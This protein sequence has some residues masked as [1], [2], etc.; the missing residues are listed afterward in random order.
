M[1]LRG[2]NAAARTERDS[3][4]SPVLRCAGSTL[5]RALNSSRVTAFS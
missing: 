3:H 1:S 2:P 4:P 5:L